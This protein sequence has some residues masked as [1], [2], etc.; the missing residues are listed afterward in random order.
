MSRTKRS[1]DA[2]KGKQVKR[3]TNLAIDTISGKQATEKTNL[4]AVYPNLPHDEISQEYL[5]R[6]FSRPDRKLEHAVYELTRDVGYLHQYYLLREEDMVPFAGK[7]QYDDASDTMIARIGNH[8]VAG[9]R[10]TFSHPGS[11][12]LLPMEEDGFSLAE[13][14]PELP[15]VDAPYVEISRMAILPEFEN[16]LLMLEFSRQLLKRA[17]EKK[18]RYAFTLASVPLANSYRK[19]AQLFGLQWIIRNDIVIPEREAYE[20][21]KMVL[22]M[23]DLAPVYRSK[24]KT[25]R[26]T[27]E[28]SLASA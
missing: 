10:L 4:A 8:C 15:L 3:M 5:A 11:R 9:C 17:A 22:C 20:G 18:T 23:L 2:V 25:A 24:A 14:L 13:A 7:D 28:S 12:S 16:S 19:A 6:R 27:R 26:K 1:G 21:A